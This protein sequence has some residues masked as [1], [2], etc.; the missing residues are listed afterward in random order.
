MEKEEKFEF[1]PR[2]QEVCKMVRIEYGL[3]QQSLLE[4]EI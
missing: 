3:N 4:V 1:R 2:P